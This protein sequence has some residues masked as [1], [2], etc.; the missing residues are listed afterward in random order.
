MAGLG[1]ALLNFSLK[2]YCHLMAHF[3]VKGKVQSRASTAFRKLFLLR[4]SRRVPC[5]DSPVS[6]PCVGDQERVGG[7][8]SGPQKALGTDSTTGQVACLFPEEGPCWSCLYVV[9]SAQN[10]AW[11]TEGTQILS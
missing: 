6:K 7:A 11:P 8:V 1:Q 2:R 4:G 10:S 3:A 5:N 9:P